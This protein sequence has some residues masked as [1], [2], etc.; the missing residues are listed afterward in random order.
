MSV[1][2]KCHIAWPGKVGRIAL[3][4]QGQCPGRGC[5]AAEIRLVDVGCDQLEQ[6]YGVKPWRFGQVGH[7]PKRVLCHSAVQRY[8]E[9]QDRLADTGVASTTRQQVA[10]LVEGAQGA[11]RGLRIVVAVGNRRT[12]LPCLDIDEVPQ[13]PGCH[14][15]A[16]GIALQ[17]WPVDKLCQ[18]ESRGYRGQ[19][20]D[21][22]AARHRRRAEHARQHEWRGNILCIRGE[23]PATAG[24]VDNPRCI[25]G[26][27]VADVK[28]AAVVRTASSQR[29]RAIAL[30]AAVDGDG[31]GDYRF[32]AAEQHALDVL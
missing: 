6:R 3:E 7:R 16:N 1:L 29:L 30:A 10:Q 4:Q 28:G 19:F 13:Q 25:V 2:I 18:C 21:G 15:H 12:R 31:R 8:C 24:Q 32:A 27:P 20:I 22:D 14:L 26:C 23:A 17:I 5:V 9:L 11:V